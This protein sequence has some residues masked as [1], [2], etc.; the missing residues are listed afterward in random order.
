MAKDFSTMED[1]NRSSNP[2]IH[3][4]SDPARRIVLAGFSQGCAMTLMTGLRYP[5]ALAGLV[6]MSGYLPLADTTAAERSPASAGLPIFLAHGRQ[7]PIIPLARAEASRAALAELQKLGATLVRAVPGEEGLALDDVSAD[8]GLGADTVLLVGER[9]ATSA[10]A[11]SAA[12]ALAERLA[13]HFARFETLS[14]PDGEAHKDWPTMDRILTTLLE[15]GCDRKTVLVA[16]GGGVVGDIT[17]FAAACYMRGIPFVQVPTTLLAQVDSSVGG[18]TAIN[19]GTGKILIGAFH[20]PALVLADLPVAERARHRQRHDRRHLDRR[21]R[22]RA[23]R[24][25]GHH[26]HMKSAA[27]LLWRLWIKKEKTS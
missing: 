17:G 12:A 16:L 26:R 20:Q 2:D 19:T 5:E 23:H 7:D 24:V 1:S 27:A 15:A 8:L 3:S 10:G 6:G 11:L 9:L 25:G 4:V 21:P 18:K 13:S 14:L 22:L